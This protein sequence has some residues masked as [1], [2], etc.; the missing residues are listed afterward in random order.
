VP[1][2]TEVWS[3]NSPKSDAFFAMLTTPEDRKAQAQHIADDADRR[4]GSMSW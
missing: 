4:A 1:V 3:M 2:P